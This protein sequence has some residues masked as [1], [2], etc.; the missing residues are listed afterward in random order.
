MNQENQNSK[1]IGHKNDYGRK[2]ENAQKHYLTGIRHSGKE[3]YA[4]VDSE[5][6]LLAFWLA[7]TP[8]RVL[9]K[10]E[11]YLHFTTVLLS[12][13]ASSIVNLIKEQ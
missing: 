11:I 7:K 6:Y 13:S 1:S 2:N 8:K 10:L 5:R 12:V 3:R 9:I 4:P